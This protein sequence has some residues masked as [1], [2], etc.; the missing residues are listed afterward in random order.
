MLQYKGRGG[1]LIEYDFCCECSYCHR[2]PVTRR[3]Y[4]IEGLFLQTYGR[5]IRKQSI[6][7]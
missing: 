3:N 5:P 6:Y 4:N 7:R 2:G 1:E